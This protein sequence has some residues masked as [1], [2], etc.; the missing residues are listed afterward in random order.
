MEDEQIVALFF[1]RSE[2]AVAE[3]DRKFGR[4]CR[5]IASRILEDDE[6]AEDIVND[7][8]MKLWET[9]PPNRP[10]KLKPYIG[11][12]CRQLA[13]NVCEKRQAKKRGQVSLI[14]DELSECLTDERE[15]ED[16]ASE[17]AFRDSLNVFLAGLP[18]KTRRIFLR[19]YWYADTV[20]EIAADFSMKESAVAMLLFRTRK[21][22]KTFLHKEGYHL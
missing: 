19:R 10:E 13:L 7:T 12:I 20:A 16:P 1:E 2:S 17:I 22:L 15:A 21:K 4:Y 5:Y 8:Y 14:L 3:T 11:M 18:S 6:D 9:I